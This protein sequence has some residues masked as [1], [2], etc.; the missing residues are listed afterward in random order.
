[1]ESTRQ[2]AKTQNFE[3]SKLSCAPA[4]KNLYLGSVNNAIT[5]NINDT[6]YTIPRMNANRCIRN[7]EIS[8]ALSKLQFYISVDG[9]LYARHVDL[10]S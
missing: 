9:Q 10:T 8:S 6:E 1:M 2:N 5:F 3:T 7:M 4:F